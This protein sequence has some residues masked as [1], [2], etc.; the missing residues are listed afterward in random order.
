M[1]RIILIGLICVLFDARANGQESDDY[2]IYAKVLNEFL[3]DGNV[4]RRKIILERESQNKIDM[5]PDMTWDETIVG[6][7][8][9]LDSANRII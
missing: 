4:K 3:R 5:S 8:N 2:L 6:L 9:K 1:K 7:S